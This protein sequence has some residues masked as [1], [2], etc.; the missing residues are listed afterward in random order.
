MENVKIKS[1][2]AYQGRYLFLVSIGQ[3]DYRVTLSR[4]YWLELTDGSQPAE[5]LILDSIM[6]LLSHEPKE[7]ILKEFDLEDIKKYFPEFEREIKN[8]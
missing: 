2:G 5:Q 1:I 6:F 7:S 8:I 4:D 3:V